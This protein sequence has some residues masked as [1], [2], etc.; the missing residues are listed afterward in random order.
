MPCRYVIVCGFRLSIVGTNT[1]TGEPWE[2]R[3]KPS[4]GDKGIALLRR[5]H[6]HLRRTSVGGKRLVP[7]GR[8]FPERGLYRKR[9]RRVVAVRSSVQSARFRYSTKTYQDKYGVRTA[10]ALPTATYKQSRQASAAMGSHET[11]TALHVGSPDSPFQHRKTESA[12]SIAIVN[13]EAIR[14]A[15]RPWGPRARHDTL[16]ES[17]RTVQCQK[18]TAS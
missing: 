6:A 10:S 1:G 18:G 15:A 14:F 13:G 17:W 4:S 11:P 7:V 16:A 8:H 3:R 9:A 2:M 12:E 5:L